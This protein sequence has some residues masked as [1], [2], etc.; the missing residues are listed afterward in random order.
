TRSPPSTRCRATDVPMLPTPMIAV[1]MRFLLRT[2]R[3]SAQEM[4]LNLDLEVDLL[5]H[6]EAARLD[7]HV[8]GHPPVLAVDRRPRGRGEHRLP[9]HVG[10]P[11][12][13]LPGERDRSGDVL[14]REVAVEL[15]RRP[16][17]RP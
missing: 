14:D 13:E 11:S 8:P 6:Q 10:S 1:I 4:R 3:G 2:R 9:F 5:A 15:E 16:T 7:R 17:P 12:E